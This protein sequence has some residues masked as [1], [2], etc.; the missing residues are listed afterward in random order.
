LLQSW[1]MPLV[2][3]SLAV[4]VVAVVVTGVRTG[5]QGW[6]TFKDSK[7]LSGALGA[8]LAALS[9]ATARLERSA[10]ALEGRS[11]KL[12]AALAR[13]A[14]SRRRLAV[15]TGAIEEVEA[16]LGRITFFFPRK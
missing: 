8:R 9:Q 3:I 4:S 2:W 6:A 12:E 11:A 10:A 14:A 15:L 13:F 1:D 5:R 7:R 16:T